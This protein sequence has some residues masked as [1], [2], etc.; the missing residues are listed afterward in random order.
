MDRVYLPNMDERHIQRVNGDESESNPINNSPIRVEDESTD[1]GI[2]SDSEPDET[3]PI[4]NQALIPNSRKVETNVHIANG[5]TIIIETEGNQNMAADSIEQPITPQNEDNCDFLEIV[6]ESVA[7]NI[8]SKKKKKKVSFSDISSFYTCRKPLKPKLILGSF[9]TL[10]SLKYWGTKNKQNEIESSEEDQDNILEGVQKRKGNLGA[11]I[12]HPNKLDALKE[13]TKEASKGKPKQK[14]RINQSRIQ[15]IL[16]PKEANVHISNFKQIKSLSYEEQ[17]N[18]SP[19]G[20]NHGLSPQLNVIVSGQESSEEE[21]NP[22]V[23]VVCESEQNLMNDVLDPGLLDEISLTIFGVRFRCPSCL[24]CDDKVRIVR[25]HIVEAH[26]VVGH[27]NDTLEPI[28][29]TMKVRLPDV[30]SKDPM[31]E[32][33]L[34]ESMDDHEDNECFENE[35][36]AETTVQYESQKSPQF[37]S[38]PLPEPHTQ[39]ETHQENNPFAKLSYKNIPDHYS[40]TNTLSDIQSIHEQDTA[41]DQ[42]LVQT[43][44][45]DFWKN[46]TISGD[47]KYAQDNDTPNIMSD[48]EMSEEGSIHSEHAVAQINEANYLPQEIPEKLCQSNPYFEQNSDTSSTSTKLVMDLD[49]ETEGGTHLFQKPLPKTFPDKI[50][51]SKELTQIE[52]PLDSDP[53]S[54]GDHDDILQLEINRNDIQSEISQHQIE[55]GIDQQILL[56]EDDPNWSGSLFDRMSMASMSTSSDDIPEKIKRKPRSETRKTVIKERNHDSSLEYSDTES[57]LKIWEKGNLKNLKQRKKEK[58]ITE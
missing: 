36:F 28:R 40:L 52:D 48:H 27:F 42:N 13:N 55:T 3:E 16:K 19:S 15:T 24:F 25:E 10:K 50:D 44:D 12:R 39:K 51:S 41:E 37:H 26:Q 45:E 22:I 47:Q 7:S 14:S 4:E 17:Q 33:D 9:T 56:E 32:L 46:N 8:S 11:S 35:N 38:S 49:F 54:Y 18:D 2:Y 21:Y 6:Y 1:D 34:H 53:T 20:M 30:N 23:T 57:W 29:Q 58:M 5:Q 43:N 31:D